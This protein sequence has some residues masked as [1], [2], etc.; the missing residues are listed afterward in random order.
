M[1]IWFQVSAQPL[2]K[3]TGAFLASG[4]A[5]MKHEVKSEPQNI[6]ERMILYLSFNGR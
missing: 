3:K 4:G 1:G 5:Y 2:A 6:E